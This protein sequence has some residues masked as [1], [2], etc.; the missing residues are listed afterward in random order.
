MKPEMKLITNAFLVE[1]IMLPKFYSVEFELYLSAPENDD[2]KGKLIIGLTD[3]LENNE[4]PGY[5]DPTFA[6]DE[7]NFV[8]KISSGKKGERKQ[9]IPITGEWYSK[10]LS[11]K[12]MICLLVCIIFTTAKTSATKKSFSF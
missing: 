2:G 9:D 10:W 7:L 3:G 12:M 4:A 6:I 5:R 11:F 8:T 1:D